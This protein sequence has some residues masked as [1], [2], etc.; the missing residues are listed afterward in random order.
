[1]SFAVARPP[2]AAVPLLQPHIAL[3]DPLLLL[4]AAFV[5]LTRAQCVYVLQ[6]A[7]CNTPV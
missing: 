4:H 1:M 5:A 6:P 7:S 3:G 2:A